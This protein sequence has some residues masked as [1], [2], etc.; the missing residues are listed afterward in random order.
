MQTDPHLIGML[1]REEFWNPATSHRGQAQLILVKN[2]DHPLG[3]LNLGFQP[4]FSRFLEAD[5]ISAETQSS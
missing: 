3:T 1:H 2:S 4:M 5:T